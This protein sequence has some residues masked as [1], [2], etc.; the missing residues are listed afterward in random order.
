MGGAHLGVGKLGDDRVLQTHDETQQHHC[1]RHEKTGNRHQAR[2]E[3]TEQQQQHGLQC[4]RQGVL[5]VQTAAA[6]EVDHQRRAHRA[7]DEREQGAEAGQRQVGGPEG[8][9]V[10]HRRDDAGHV[11]SVLLDG[12]EPAG[13]GGP[14]NEGEAQ[15]ELAIAMGGSSA[16]GQT[17]GVVD[18]HGLAR[19]RQRGGDYSDARKGACRC[20]PAYRPRMLSAAG[21]PCGRRRVSPHAV[22]AGVTVHG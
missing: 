12:D 22:Y 16:I 15:A 21:P 9:I 17:T 2:A 19:G 4:Q 3:D 6:R 8:Q 14:R 11:R 1:Q 18:G 20:S 7:K 10:G 5:A 13:I